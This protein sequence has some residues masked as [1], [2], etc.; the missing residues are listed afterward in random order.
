MA[1]KDATQNKG[2]E[3]NPD[4]K[5]TK[6]DASKPEEKVEIKVAPRARD[7]YASH[8]AGKHRQERDADLVT[9]A[10]AEGVKDPVAIDTLNLTDDNKP[11]APEHP[12]ALQ[13]IEREGPPGSETDPEK[14]K[15][16]PPAET[17][18]ATLQAGSPPAEEM[19]EATVY[20]EKS[21]VAKAEVDEAGGLVAY[22]KQKAAE[23]NLEQAKDL[24]ESARKT[25]AAIE[26]PA[27]NQ[28]GGTPDK[29]ATDSLSVSD[30]DF[31]TAVEAIQDGTTE[32][33]VE[34]LHKLLSQVGG[35]STSNDTQELV[36]EVYARIEYDTAMKSFTAK[37]PHIMKDPKLVAMVRNRDGELRQNPDE[38]RGFEDR[39]LAIGAEIDEW[40]TGLGGEAKPGD[41]PNKKTDRQ[42]RKESSEAEPPAANTRQGAKPGAGDEANPPPRKTP[43]QV[44]ND[45]AKSRGQR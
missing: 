45:I 30:E 34:A 14:D 18:P 6:P 19:V 36:S 35:Q 12:D 9:N 15:D 13:Q 39:Y 16:K 11:P 27:Q 26:T 25:T 22:Q 43:R 32:E 31:A 2:A 17:P 40:L 5:G 8:I 33:G 3:G 10:R 28:S 29:P 41:P 7:Q 38:A 20:G 44:V 23:K 37:Y 24:L 21:M 42:A 4:D 1:E